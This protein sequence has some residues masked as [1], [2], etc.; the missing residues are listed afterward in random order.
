M[1]LASTYVSLRSAIERRHPRQRIGLRGCFFLYGMLRQL[2]LRRT[3]LCDNLTNHLATL[4]VKTFTLTK[5]V[6]YN[7]LL[8]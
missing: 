2:V 6:R 4:K 5:T 7:S 8:L 1:F 3:V